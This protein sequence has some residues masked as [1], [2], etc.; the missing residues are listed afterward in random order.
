MLRPGHPLPPHAE[1]SQFGRSCPQQGHTDSAQ[2]LVNQA[3][4]QT[5]FTE[6]KLR[7]RQR[8]T[9][10]PRTLRKSRRGVLIRTWGGA[11]HGSFSNN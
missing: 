7:L 1:P 4:S 8:D 6:E 9:T 2:G 11:R 10:C 3:D 5:H